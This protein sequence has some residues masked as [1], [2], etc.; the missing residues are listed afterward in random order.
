[1]TSKCLKCGSQATRPWSNAPRRIVCNDCGRTSTVPMSDVSINITDA[2]VQTP[3]LVV[4]DVLYSEK[5]CHGLSVGATVVALFDAHLE[6]GK[7]HP[8][9]RIA[10][11]FT[12]D[13]QPTHLIIG[14]DFSEVGSLSAWQ[15]PGHI[16][17]E[18]KRYASDVMQ[19]RQELDDFEYSLP[20][21]Q[22]IYIGGNHEDRV[23]RYIEKC[24][25][26]EGKL[27]WARDVGLEERG[28]SWYPYNDYEQNCFRL[29]EL[30]YLHGTF[31]NKYYARTTL[32]SIGDNCVF[33]H[34]H[35][36][37]HWTQRL[38]ARQ[39]PHAAWGVGCLCDVNPEWKRGKPT[40][41]V[42][43]FAYIEYRKD[44]TFNLHELFI[45]NGALIF[46]GH[47]WSV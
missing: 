33:G 42:N 15:R 27:D 2:F 18:G 35:K 12:L 45:I 21:T 16:E 5:G 43:S 30:L 9:Y 39:R 20:D 3:P 28:I 40:D 4:P 1:M 36:S 11:Q 17:L 6:P 44:K 13:M 10:R 14:G 24:P 41:F 7:A 19:V 25:Q 38:K 37:Q 26:L 32:E 22:I 8:A 34:A 31:Y 29:G 47:V 23:R 46:D